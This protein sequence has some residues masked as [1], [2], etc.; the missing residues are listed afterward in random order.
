MRSNVLIA[1][2]GIAIISCTEVDG[3]AIESQRQSV[4]VADCTAATAC[5]STENCMYVGSEGTCYQ[6]CDD[7][8]GGCS[9][10]KT[11]TAS[12]P[13]CCQSIPC[14]QDDATEP[15]DRTYYI[16]G[17]Q[18]GCHTGVSCAACPQGKERMVNDPGNPNC[19]TPTYNCAG[20]QC[21]RVV[22]S[23]GWQ[24]FNEPCG[25][26]CTTPGQ[27]CV[28]NHCVCNQST[29]PNGCCDANNVCQ[30]GTTPSACGTG[31][32]ACAPCSSGSCVNQAC[33]TCGPGN[34]AG[35]CCTIGGTCQPG[36]SNTY[37]G[38]PNG[39]LCESCSPGGDR[40]HCVN[41]LCVPY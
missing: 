25:N 33:S 10:G 4:L 29:C 26:S 11:C 34:C 15:A 12:T 5:P 41:R 24:S 8:G 39:A 3:A 21:G 2:A 19:C 9:S 40:T 37:C 13:Y 27:T 22:D 30:T 17:I 36:T 38:G 16:V 6:T 7:S 35:G 32:A 14:V 28:N 20:I 1:F 18:S 31:G 23:C